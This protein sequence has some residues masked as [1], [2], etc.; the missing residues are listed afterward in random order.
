MLR[1]V[2]SCAASFPAF[3]AEL[4]GQHLAT[5]CVRNVA[6]DERRGVQFVVDRP[7]REHQAAFR[8]TDVQ[9]PQRVVRNVANLHQ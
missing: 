1:T 6:V 2:K 9:F 4:A 5:R 8:G 3:G 7:S